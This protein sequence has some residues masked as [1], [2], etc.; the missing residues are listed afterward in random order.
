MAKVERTRRAS[1][2]GVRSILNVSGKDADFEYRITNDTG[3]RVAL[4]QERGYEVV[5]DDKVSIGERR[6]ANPTQ[7]GSVVSAS[8]GG[9]VRGVL[10]KIRKD[11]YNE[12]QQAKQD[13]VNQTEGA[14]VQQSREGFS[15]K[16]E[17][18]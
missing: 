14:M 13:Q 7:Q 17:L 8:V 12:D 15:G 9:G 10:M 4:M 5:T 2:N 18:S 3:D 11:W 1:V 6:V 16:L